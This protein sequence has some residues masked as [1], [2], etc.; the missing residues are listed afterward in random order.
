MMKKNTISVMV[1]KG[2]LS[3]NCRVFHAENVDPS[4]THLNIEYCNDNIREV[5]HELFDE[6]VARYNAK[7]KR[8]DRKIEDYYEKIR[9]GRQ[10]KPF[11]EM[12]IQI[13]NRDTCGSGTSDGNFAARLLNQYMKGFQERNPTLRV[14]SAHLHMDES[15]PHIHIDFVPYITGSKRGVDTR[16]SLKQALG[17][18]G[19]KGGSRND[20]EWDQWANAEKEVLAEI[21][22][23]HG[24]EWE[25]KG[26]HEEHLSVLDYKKK[27]RAKEVAALEERRADLEEENR[28]CLAESDHLRSELTIAREDL[29]E[30]L[31]QKEKAEQAAVAEKAEMEKAEVLRKQSQQKADELQRYVKP[32]E[33]DV[34]E[35]NDAKKW[36]LP[37][38]DLLMTAKGYRDKK[39]L[40][41][42]KKLKEVIFNLTIQLNQK[43]T[44]IQNLRRQL[45]EKEQRIAGQSNHIDDLKNENAWLQKRSNTLGLLERAVGSEQVEQIARRQEQ[46]EAMERD[47]RRRQRGQG[48]SL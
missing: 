46:L 33:K 3:H 17:A 8:S 11:H 5:Y 36:Q 28:S 20:N 48:Y 26:T 10:E 44:E 13:G 12:V 21:M 1:G 24:I 45:R 27:E 41:L 4:R 25:K 29:R 6:A 32:L 30:A 31:D 9:S 14:F 18:L 37:E 35:Y 16:V 22:R 2:S 7:Q 39:A 47:Q 34:R 42:V 43:L 38:P 19:F 23:E 40:P 15:T